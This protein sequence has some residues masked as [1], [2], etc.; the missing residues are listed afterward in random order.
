M[1]FK[2]VRRAA[3]CNWPKQT[4]SIIDGLGPLQMVLELG[5][6]WCARE[7][8]EH[9]RGVDC[10]ITHWLERGTKRFL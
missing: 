10:K 7:D 6:E 4:I 3:I 1:R 5:T 8:V 9:R 2:I